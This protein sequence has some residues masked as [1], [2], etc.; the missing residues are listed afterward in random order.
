MLCLASVWLMG[1]HHSVVRVSF[2]S[3]SLYQK[4][5]SQPQRVTNVTVTY[6]APPVF[7]AFSM[8]QDSWEAPGQPGPILE[9]QAGP[10]I[11]VR[12]GL[13]KLAALLIGAKLVVAGWT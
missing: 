12:L 2:P 8:A 13:R 10:R 11:V 5:S 1:G 7:K 9:R 6:T 3:I 4:L